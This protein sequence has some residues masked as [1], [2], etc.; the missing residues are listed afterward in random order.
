MVFDDIKDISRRFPN[1]DL[2][3]LHL[4]GTTI[5]GIMVTMDSKEG[6]RMFRIIHPKMAI[7]IHYNDYDV[8]K[9]SLDDFKKEVSK[10]GIGEHIHYLN[11]GE[12]YTF[13]ID[14]K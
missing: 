5:M 4:G 14:K 3:L 10:A 8:F 9:S 7:P 12:R 13:E 2:A 1:T 6:I 11:H